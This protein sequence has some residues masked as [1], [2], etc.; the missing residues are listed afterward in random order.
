MKKHFNLLDVF[1]FSCWAV[2]IKHSVLQ[3]PESHT[4]LSKTLGRV[5]FWGSPVH[6]FHACF[7]P[8]WLF[9][10]KSSRLSKINCFRTCWLAWPCLYTLVNKSPVPMWWVGVVG[11][12]WHATWQ[13][14]SRHIRA[15]TP[16]GGM[17]G[18]F[19]EW[20]HPVFFNTVLAQLAS[21]WVKRLN[22]VVSLT[23]KRM[24]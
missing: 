16:S 24:G 1:Q 19:L 23:F 13:G 2:M 6:D 5:V 22:Q 8:E 15:D 7:F 18:T 9:T 17:P 14:H 10:A 20:S 4:R 21:A 12:W 11:T 3:D